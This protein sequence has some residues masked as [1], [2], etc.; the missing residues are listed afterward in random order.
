M[1]FVKNVKDCVSWYR[2][3]EHAHDITTYL[4]FVV[5]FSIVSFAS[6][7][8]VVQ[9]NIQE[10]TKGNF[11]TCENEN[12]DDFCEVSTVDGVL[13]YLQNTWAGNLFPS[14]TYNG[15]P[16]N[17]TER[18]FVNG[19]SRFMGAY[20]VRVLRSVEEE[21]MVEDWLSDVGGVKMS[22][23]SAFS[24]GNRDKENFG[25]RQEG[26]N[27]EDG[28][29]MQPPPGTPSG[30]PYWGNFTLPFTYQSAGDI[31]TTIGYFEVGYY[32]T[33]TQDG[34]NLDIIPNVSPDILADKLQDCRP[35]VQASLEKCME[36][37][38]VDYDLP[39]SPPPPPPYTAPPPPNNLGSPDTAGLVV[40]SRAIGETNFTYKITAEITLSESDNIGDFAFKLHNPG[41]VAVDF[42]LDTD[43]QQ[44]LLST[45]W[46]TTSP[47]LSTLSGMLEPIPE[48]MSAPTDSDLPGNEYSF[49]FG[50]GADY[51]TYAKTAEEQII[52]PFPTSSVTLSLTSPT[53]GLT[54]IVDIVMKYKIPAN[55][56]STS[57]RRLLSNPKVIAVPQRD[58]ALYAGRKL[59][60]LGSADCSE[61]DPLVIPS[62]LD[63]SK[64]KMLRDLDGIC[65]APYIGFQQMVDLLSPGKCGE[66]KCKGDVDEGC[67]TSCSASNIFADQLDYL[68]KTD[69]IHPGLTRALVA[70]FTVLHQNF[71][72]F[73]TVRLMFE[74]PNIGGV[75]PRAVV[76]TF[77]LY[78]YVTGADTIVMGLE[79]VFIAMVFYFTVE[80][81]TEIK[82]QGLI[83]LKNPWNYMDWANL[84][85]IYVVIVMRVSSV[86]YINSF[87]YDSVTT[88]YVDFMPLG[89]AAIAELNISSLNFFLI[90]FK[91]FKYLSHVP[92]MD[93]MLV[94]VSTCAFD[95]LL[96]LLMFFVIL[97]GFASA[98]FITFGADVSDF[99]T[100]SESFGTLMR[101][102][103][104]D[105]DY[106]ALQE[107][108][109]V[110]APVLFYF[111]NVIVFFIL[112][113]MFLAIICDAFAEVKGN[114][115]EEDLMYYINLK[116]QLV[117]KLSEL[118]S[119]KKKV[120][121]LSAG[122][123]IADDNIDGLIDEEEL[124]KVLERNPKALEILKSSSPKELLA[125]YDVS[126]DGVLDRKEMTAILKELAEKEAELSEEMQHEEDTA[127]N[128]SNEAQKLQG[129]LDKDRVGGGG[130]GVGTVIQQ[131]D[132]TEVEG[133]IDKV[134]GH[135]K[136]MS[137]NVAK[138][139][140][141]M[142]DLMMSL[143]DQISSVQGASG[144]APAGSQIVPVPPGSRA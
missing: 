119:R 90:Y 95:L 116:D 34:Y 109:S 71:N 130:G 22:C 96:F 15:R 58:R 73:T 111:F 115:T 118:R 106:G 20:R 35:L 107:A 100:L 11:A 120:Q 49:T 101:I 86:M 63:V 136:E 104:G 121:E 87:D 28:Y 143:S 46:I 45:D 85:I 12:S 5:I 23:I 38:D 52:D 92:R 134:E 47:A 142:I 33:Y 140:S 112:L 26:G 135:I 82:K 42:E 122:L 57:G 40:T 29:L 66:C 39:P 117:S 54:A 6:K 25:E 139:L 62:M 31:N 79:F 8:G 114:Q 14:H 75:V 64:C 81:I 48:G 113:N 80:E 83:Y 124:T 50:L 27:D 91:V 61:M 60:Q 108:N 88:E 99:R 43:S 72:L 59:Q 131:V 84:I 77:R 44:A 51:G 36:E 37:Q 76:R 1:G 18:L 9:F 30:A 128:A 16:L 129:R 7:P 125:K 17:G 132:L 93:S 56:T 2:K 137:R 89:F 133:R 68:H 98:F 24:L 144:G 94:T 102:L 126:G 67:L 110:M 127:A 3:H 70:D 32:A 123:A 141:L 21:C 103:L 19:Q 13:G 41:G 78:R 138:K 53:F 55:T 69:W 74:M 97:F 65:D 105:F 10:M 4:V